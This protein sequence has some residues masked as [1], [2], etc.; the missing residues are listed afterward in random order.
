MKK[1]RVLITY[2]WVR[3]SYAALRNLR[4]RGYEVF[5]ADSYKFGMGQASFLHSGFEKYTSH[6]EDE[7][8]FIEDILE[9][10]ENR[11]IDFILPSHNE[12][13][14]L[15]KY[16]QL[17]DER[18]VSILPDYKMTKVFNNKA[19]TYNLVE[20]LGV[21][22]PRRVNY[23][24][25]TDLRS[26]LLKKSIDKAVVKLLTGNGSHGVYYANSIN[27][28]VQLVKRL[29]V[30]HN[31]E[32]TRLPLVEQYV[33]GMGWGVS[34]LFWKGEKVATFTHKRLRE[35][36]STGGSS[37]LRESAENKQLEIAAETIF[38]NVKWHG[39]AMAE[40]KY[41][42]KTKKYWFIEINPRLWGSLPL[43]VNS[44]AEFPHWALLCA[45]HGIK[46]A[47]NAAA[48]SVVSSSWRGRWLLGD[49]TVAIRCIFKGN[50]K[51]ALQIFC[52]TSYDS[53]DD[54]FLDDVFVFFG[55][56]FHYAEKSYYKLIGKQFDGKM[57]R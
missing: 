36:I 42:E 56:I 14:I 34:V 30:E 43:A 50:L 11:K 49:I 9:I 57:I 55:Q 20:S 23:K 44:G 10:C 40:F 13:E 52:S 5:V 7:T 15:S 28:T 41:C 19:K 8:A 27:E 2:S 38:S 47:Q 46:I 48:N 4:E 12:T 45:E 24:D 33:D 22:V 53:S 25:E 17:F 21:S 29:K 39:I 31:L 16:T 54:F 26:Q 1:T 3:S 37:T 18:L 51:Q 32:Q 6:Y 35:K